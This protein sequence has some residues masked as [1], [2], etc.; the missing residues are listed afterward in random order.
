VDQPDQAE[1][2]QHLVGDP[3]HRAGFVQTSRGVQTIDIID[4]QPLQLCVGQA[5]GRV[6][7]RCGGTVDPRIPHGRG[8]I[9]ALAGAEH[10]RMAGED[11]FDQGGTRPGHADDENRQPGR[12]PATA[13][14]ADQPGGEHRPYPVQHA[15]RRRL[16]VGDGLA[17]E[18]VA[19][20][21]VAKRRL[22]PADIGECLAESKMEPDPVI[23]VQ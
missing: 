4:A 8:E 11:L 23:L 15:E 22:V 13:I 19:G 21:Q 17:L 1:I 20:E 3:R 9:R 2:R 10:V 7:K 12:M 16:V 6:Q 14:A 18:R 5:G